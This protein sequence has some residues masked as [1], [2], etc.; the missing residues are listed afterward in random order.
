M[1]STTTSVVGKRK[2]SAK[3]ARK[4]K[5]QQ[6]RTSPHVEED[7]D[8][9]SSS[10]ASS[11]NSAEPYVVEF[12]LYILLQS[13]FERARGPH[14]CRDAGSRRGWYERRCF[15]ARDKS[16]PKIQP[17]DILHSIG[18]LIARMLCPRKRRFADHWA[19]TA[20]GAVPKGTFGSFV[21]KARFDR[22][23]Q[24]LHFTN[25]ADPQAETDHAL[26][27]RSVVDTLQQTFAKGY[28]TPPVLSFD[29]AMIASRSRHNVT[30][31]FMKD[32]PHKWGTKVFMTC[33]ADTA[34]CLR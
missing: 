33:C 27:I 5:R 34:Y 30:R 10:A 11:V 23:M 2:A 4:A 13:T 29:E 7:A 6:K 8:G 19:T 15:D 12:M 16:P 22:I 9:G 28:T 24:N 17:E 32:K 18:L 26:K 20:V 31:Q 21:R 14:V 3:P 25:N 1:A